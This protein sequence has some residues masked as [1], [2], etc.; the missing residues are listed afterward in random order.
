MLGSF[1]WTKMRWEGDE[2]R[3]GRREEWWVGAGSKC[4]CAG[5]RQKLR[6]V[7]SVVYVSHFQW[8]V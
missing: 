3:L 1:W 5:D 2:G 6:L 7:V 8:R 4:E